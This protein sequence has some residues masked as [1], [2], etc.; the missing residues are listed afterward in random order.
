MP[1]LPLTISRALQLFDLYTNSVSELPEFDSNQ[2]GP[3]NAELEPLFRR[4]VTLI[5]S[6]EDPGLFFINYSNKFNSNID[7]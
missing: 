7:P 4:I 1:A 6:Q 3:L 5:P 2:P